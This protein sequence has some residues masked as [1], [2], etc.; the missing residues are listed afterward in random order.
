MRM[1]SIS[2]QLFDDLYVDTILNP[3]T[4]E[5][6]VNCA[7][8]RIRQE[9]SD[10]RDGTSILGT[11]DT[12]E[13][14]AAQRLMAHPLPHWV[15]CMTTSYLRSHG[16]NAERS[17]R[18]WT[19]TWPDGELW[20]EIVFTNRETEGVATARVL[21]LEEPRVRALVA[22]LLR[23]VPG[24]PVPR[25]TLDALSAEITGWW[26]LWSIAIHTH[27]R[28]ERRILPVF[29]HD[30]GRSLPPTAR[31]IWEQFLNASPA[32]RGYVTSEDAAQVVGALR[33][34]VEDLGHPL[35]MHLLQKH[36]SIIDREQAKGEYSF[37]AR[38]SVVERIGLPAV[39]AHRF[40][41]LDAEQQAWRNDLDSRAAVLPELQVL[42]VC[43]V[44]RGDSHV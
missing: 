37:S 17:G 27:D 16:G 18:T 12:P 20:S 24:Q 9:A 11:P 14:D 3:D 30:D 2:P 41:A 39:R 35:Y 8:E 1:A 29:L 13:P 32:I 22:H 6:K 36:Q 4:V 31:H 38:R 15:E 44:E 28:V 42:I 7:V 25:V 21:T 23:F 10:A 33:D 40:K 5:A 26:S 34:S 19:L 43:K